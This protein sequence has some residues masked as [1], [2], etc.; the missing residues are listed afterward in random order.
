MRDARG[1]VASVL[2]GPDARTSI[3]TT[4]ERALFVVYGPAGL[5]DQSI[6]RQL[7]RLGTLARLACPGA[8]AGAPSLLSLNWKRTLLRLDYRLVRRHGR[9][10]PS[11]PKAEAGGHLGPRQLS[12]AMSYSIVAGGSGALFLTVCNNQP[13]FNVYMLNHLGVSPEL[14]GT[15]LALMQFSRRAPALVD[16]RLLPP[17]PAE[18]AVDGGPRHPPPRGFRGGGLGGPLR[19]GGGQ[20]AGRPPRIGGDDRLMGGDEPDLLGLDV[21]DGRPHPRGDEGQL[22]P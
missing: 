13:I 10:M 14:L 9:A 4:T 16:H 2:L 22:L 7:E 15:L 19:L 5:P 1:I 20:G 6:V 8:R 12:R 21:L 3:S 18:V 17:A 11:S